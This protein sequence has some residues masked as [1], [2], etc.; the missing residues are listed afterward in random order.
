MC[1]MMQNDYRFI[2]VYSGKTKTISGSYRETRVSAIIAQPYIH[3]FC[4]AIWLISN[5][6]IHICVNAQMP[7]MCR[8]KVIITNVWSARGVSRCTY[9]VCRAAQPRDAWQMPIA[10]HYYMLPYSLS[11]RVRKAYA[12]AK[13]SLSTMTI[14]AN[15]G[16]ETLY[17][18]CELARARRLLAFY[19]NFLGLFS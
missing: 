16:M 18:H 7:G 17:I 5:A 3:R 2:R 10:E 11:R 1:A 6:R 14:T 8:V 9:H 4:I 12:V 13:I 19:C 15:A